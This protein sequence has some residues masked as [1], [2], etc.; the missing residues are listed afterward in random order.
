MPT[1]ILITSSATVT[2]L[3][4]SED[5]GGP[6]LHSPDDSLVIAETTTTLGQALEV[7]H[8][9]PNITVASTTDFP[10]A[11]GYVVFGFG[12]DYQVG[13]VRYLGVSGPMTLILDPAFT[14]PSDVPNGAIVNLADRMSDDQ[15]PHG[16]EDFWV[17]PSPA[18]RVSCEENI[19]DVSAAGTDVIKDVLYPGDVGLGGAGLPTHGVPRLTDAVMVWGSDDLDSE[20]ATARES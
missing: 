12:Y 5:G 2:P 20:I 1:V 16:D 8:Q 3:E 14:F 15:V 4:P 17:T 19:D 7:G 18:G 10:D 6:Y 11:E 9:Y 13:P